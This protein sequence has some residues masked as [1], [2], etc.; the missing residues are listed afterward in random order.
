MGGVLTS[1]KPRPKIA[2]GPKFVRKLL[3]GVAS[4]DGGATYIPTVPVVDDVP[5][6][7]AYLF[8]LSPRLAALAANLADQVIKRRE[9]AIV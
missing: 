9:K 6:L 7:L 5:G 2:R 4:S 3:A 8:T 1:D